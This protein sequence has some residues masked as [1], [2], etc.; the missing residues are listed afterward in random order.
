MEV[1]IN[2]EIVSSFKSMLSKLTEEPDKFESIARELNDFNFSIFFKFQYL[3]MDHFIW[4]Y[5]PGFPR[6][7][8]TISVKEIIDKKKELEKDWNDIKHTLIH[9]MKSGRQKH[10]SGRD[11]NPNEIKYATEQNMKPNYAIRIEKSYPVADV[12]KLDKLK[13]IK[14]FENEISRLGDCLRFILL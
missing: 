6:Q 12:E 10:R 5:I 13:I 2:G 14:F 4:N 7:M 8:N 9:E 1:A 3:P 11:F